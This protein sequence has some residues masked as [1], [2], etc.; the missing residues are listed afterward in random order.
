M[1]RLY[2]VT[3]SLGCCEWMGIKTTMDPDGYMNTCIVR[4]C[5]RLECALS[6]GR[7]LSITIYIHHSAE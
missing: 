1:T 2:G 6:V 7:L 4:S 5:G 3:D